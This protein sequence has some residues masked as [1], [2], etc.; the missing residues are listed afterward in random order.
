MLSEQS[1]VKQ[2]RQPLFSWLHPHVW[3][4]HILHRNRRKPAEHRAGHFSSTHEHL[5]LPLSEESHRL[6]LSRTCRGSICP[7]GSPEVD[8]NSLRYWAPGEG[9]VWT[10]TRAICLSQ[11]CSLFI[12]TMQSSLGLWAGTVAGWCSGG[13]PRGAVVSHV[14]TLWLFKSGFW[15]W[16]RGSTAAEDWKCSRRHMNTHL[17]FVAP[18][19]DSEVVGTPHY[20]QNPMTYTRFGYVMHICL[21][22]HTHTHFYNM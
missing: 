18:F 1:K 15:M 4:R 22:T 5:P 14:V 20:I 8:T 12:C 21:Y 11:S 7:K 6:R 19:T 2:E 16:P 10:F 17:C 9:Q 3:G 13:A